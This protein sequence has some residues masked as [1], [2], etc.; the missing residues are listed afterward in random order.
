MSS[1]GVEI[2]QELDRGGELLAHAALAGE[3]Q[4]PNREQPVDRQIA[5]SQRRL[6][7]L[8]PTRLCSRTTCSIPRWVSQ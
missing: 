7:Q 8:S 4:R 1:S 2:E 3:G 6:R 5:E